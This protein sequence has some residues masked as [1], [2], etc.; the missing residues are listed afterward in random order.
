M[1]FLWFRN[2]LIIS[3]STFLLP[4]LHI[5][6]NPP[7]Q[8]RTINSTQT[9]Y[10]V[11]RLCHKL[12]I[13]YF[14]VIKLDVFLRSQFKIFSWLLQYKKKVPMLKSNTETV[15]KSQRYF[16]RSSSKSTGGNPIVNPCHQSQKQ[17]HSIYVLIDRSP[18]SLRTYITVL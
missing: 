7:P 8:S 6:Y 9:Q 1:L 3:V 5:T 10:V 16:A 13:L 4:S 2:L 12:L 14:L 18:P 11:W 15:N 17:R